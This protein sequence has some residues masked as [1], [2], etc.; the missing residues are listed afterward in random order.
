M[1]MGTENIYDISTSRSIIGVRLVVS[2]AEDPQKTLTHRWY[3]VN[4]YDFVILGNHW[5]R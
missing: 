1:E 4:I 5:G 3:Y 2:Q